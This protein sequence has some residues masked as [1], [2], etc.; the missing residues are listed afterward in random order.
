MCRLWI[1]DPEASVRRALGW[2]LRDRFDL[3]DEFASTPPLARA[4]DSA[5]PFE[6][7]F[8]SRSGEWLLLALVRGEERRLLVVACRTEDIAALVR[9]CVRP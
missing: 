8:E 2:S 3:V 1:A 4:L 6:A 7:L 9:R 5:G